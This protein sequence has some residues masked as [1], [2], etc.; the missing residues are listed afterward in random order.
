M[1]T[2]PEIHAEIERLSEVSGGAVADPAQRTSATVV[3]E[4]KQIDEQLPRSGTS[5]VPSARASASASATTS[6]AVPAEERLERAAVTDVP[7]GPEMGLKGLL[8]RNE[9]PSDVESERKSL[10]RQR[11]EAAAELETLKRTLSER[12]A[13][14]QQRE[15]ELSRCA[16][17]RREAR[18]EARQVAERGSRLE[19]CGYGWPKRRRRGQ[20]AK[21]S[22]RKVL[23]QHKVRLQRPRRAEK[24]GARAKELDA[25][26]AGLSERESTLAEREAELE[27]SRQELEVRYEELDAREQEPE[28][29]AEERVSTP[30]PATADELA[31]IEAKL[32]ELGAAEEAF[33][34]HPRRACRTQRRALGAGGGAGRPRA[35]RRRQRKQTPELDAL[36]ARIRRLEQGGR[37]R[38]PEP[39]TFSAGLRALEER[40]LRGPD[41]E[42]P[43]H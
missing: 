30:A 37:K 27:R 12:V 38:G 5:T 40:G 29:P 3:D 8:D 14:V 9:E 39:Q 6:C 25:L 42:G 43:L 15:R 18:A 23:I 26:Q 20:P 7:S 17:P 31:A 1:N 41:R 16:G 34:T 32:A 24:L 2:I 22:P 4:I 28:A 36:E 21:P 10:L 19:S 33:A 13:A 35:R 11:V